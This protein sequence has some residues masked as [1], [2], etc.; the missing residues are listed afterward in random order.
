MLRMEF[1]QLHHPLEMT[2]LC[3]R[4][5]CEQV[6]DYL[7]VDNHGNEQRVCAAH[8]DSEMHASR[9]P[10]REPSPDLPFRSRPAA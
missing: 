5:G 10:V 4:R 3:D 8:T 9:L 1:F 2:V 6:A 7:E